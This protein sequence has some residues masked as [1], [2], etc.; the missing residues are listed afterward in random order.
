MSAEFEEMIGEWVFGCDIC[1]DVCPWNRDG[2]M[3]QID[4]LKPRDRVIKTPRKDWSQLSKKEFERIFEG[5]AVRR[6]GHKL[7]T[8]N[9]S[10]AE[11]NIERQEN[12][13]S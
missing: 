13:C 11:N 9:A 2:A 12:E 10:L 5:S 1:Q 3:G 7:F 8:H 4:D 6:A